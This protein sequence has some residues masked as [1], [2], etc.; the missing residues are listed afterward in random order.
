MAAA[1]SASDRF[2]RSITPPSDGLFGVLS[3]AFLIGVDVVDVVVVVVAAAVV[4]TSSFLLFRD[5]R[6]AFALRPFS[7]SSKRRG[8]RGASEAPVAEPLPADDDDD[9][10]DEDG[11]TL[12]ISI[13]LDI[14]LYLISK[15]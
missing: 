2:E 14:V 7:V 13:D 10:D 5:S 15:Q 11:E 9:D 3:D 1:R 4:V 8:T 12:A 6:S